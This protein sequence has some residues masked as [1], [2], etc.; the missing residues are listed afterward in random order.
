[1]GGIVSGA[2]DRRG[3]RQPGA[4]FADVSSLRPVSGDAEEILALLREWDAAEDP[5][6]LVIATSG[7]TGRPKRVLLSRD[8][9][10]ASANATHERLG[11]PGRWVLNLPPTHV[12]GVQVLYR[13]VLAGED[14]VT[15]QDIVHAR[16]ELAG[17]RSYVSLVPTQLLRLLEVPA[18]VK[19]LPPSTPCWSVAPPSSARCGRGPRRPG[20]RSCRRTA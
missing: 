1:M 9:M 16:A 2:P 13:S 17:G 6:P 5:E 7:S 20:S 19:S 12:A 15:T 18:A 10:R 8:A 11:G 3:R 14:P 4:R